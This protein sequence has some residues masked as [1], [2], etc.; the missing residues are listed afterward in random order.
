MA[1]VSTNYP[2]GLRVPHLPRHRHAEEQPH[3]T[4]PSELT[5]TE[6][7]TEIRTTRSRHSQTSDDPEALTEK[8]AD[9]E[10]VEEPQLTVPVCLALLGVVT[11]VGHN[12]I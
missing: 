10:E 3:P 8:S 5:V 6:P 2:A 12:F 4:D 1:F 9:E 11:V 7:V